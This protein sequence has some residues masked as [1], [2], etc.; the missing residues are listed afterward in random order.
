M[1]GIVAVILHFR[2]PDMT[3]RC[4]RSLIAERVFDAVL[5]DNSEDKGVSLAAMSGGLTELKLK[6][7]RVHNVSFGVNLGF[8][9]GANRGIARAL[10]LGLGPVLLLN[11]DAQ[12]LAGAIEHLDVALSQGGGIALPVV[13]M[14]DQVESEYFYQRHFALLCSRKVFGSIRLLSGV[15]M[16]LPSKLASSCF[17]DESFFFYG[18]DVE[19]SARLRAKGILSLRVEDA[20]IT[21]Q[22]STSAG[23]GSLFYEYHTV[24]GHWLLARKLATGGLDHALAMSGRCLVL[25]LRALVRSIRSQDFLPIK[26]FYM[27]TVDFFGGRRRTLT[28]PAATLE[29]Y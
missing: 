6:G 18:E 12:L 13:E 5:V 23:N 22:T 11:S 29:G 20:H 9:A 3:L 24:R 27:A 7:L 10:E 4:L 1:S 26:A 19:L 16:L 21:H 15:C 8:A 28:P 25:P 14:G 2:T 17:F